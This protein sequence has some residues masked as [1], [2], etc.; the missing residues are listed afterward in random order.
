MHLNVAGG[1]KIDSTA[2]FQSKKVVNN[3]KKSVSLDAPSKPP[4][5]NYKLHSLVPVP[6]PSN[7]V[8]LDVADCA[9]SDTAGDLEDSDIEL[10][11]KSD[12]SKN[13]NLNSLVCLSQDLEYLHLGRLHFNFKYYARPVEF[14][15]FLVA[16]TIELVAELVG[17]TTLSLEFVTLQHV[18]QPYLEDLALSLNR[19]DVVSEPECEHKNDPVTV[20]S[21]GLGAKQRCLS[22]IDLIAAK[23]PQQLTVDKDRMLFESQEREER[24]SQQRHVLFAPCSVHYSIRLDSSFWDT[25]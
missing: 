23:P 20:E 2:S 3:S 21:N 10:L 19:I 11:D 5:Q 24:Q 7:S 9:A 15:D 25:C 13:N 18:L 12:L 4:L 14:G 1:S 8:D 6:E 16:E 22:D 17:F